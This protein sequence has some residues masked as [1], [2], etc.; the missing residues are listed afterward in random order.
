V[1]GATV[2][3][4][5]ACLHCIF[6]FALKRKYIGENPTSGVKHFNERTER[7]TKRMLTVE[8]EHRILETAPP[9]LRVAIV[10]LVQTGGRTYS[11][12]LSLKW[13]Q[14]DLAHGVIHL[15]GS[16]KTTDS[17]QPL[18]LSRLACDVLKEWKKEQGSESPFVFP[19]PRSPGKPI[20]SVK[21]AWRT[22]LKNA[23]VPY[24]PIYNLRHVFC[25]RLSWVAPD[26][27]VQRAMRHSSPETKRHYQLG[28]VDQVR[29]GI[30]RANERAYQGKQKLLR[31]YYVSPETKEEATNASQ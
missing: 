26:A 8:D 10:L 29:E 7:P 12:G 3:R 21:H 28:M 5:L 20:R 14:V 1:K 22:T 18:P 31:F 4:E 2:N 25:T 15:G 17:A 9:Y 13:E 23:G 27:V 6:Q 30:E 16:V 24:F 11:E 19:S